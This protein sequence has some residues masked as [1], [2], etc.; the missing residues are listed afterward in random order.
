MRRRLHDI[1][2]HILASLDLASCKA[3]WRTRTQIVFVEDAKKRGKIGFLHDTLGCHHNTLEFAKGVQRR[4]FEFPDGSRLLFLKSSHD[5]VLRHTSGKAGSL[6]K[7]HNAR[8]CL[9][10]QC[11]DLELGLETCDSHA[12]HTSIFKTS[13]SVHDLLLGVVDKGVMLVP[14]TGLE[15][16]S[17]TPHGMRKRVSVF[18]CP[19]SKCRES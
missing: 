9:I 3:E 19:P 6:Q 17:A 10:F 5:I 13:L 7:A 16:H 8:R 15:L 12:S 1:H 18:P 4:D 2:L 11:G 14:I